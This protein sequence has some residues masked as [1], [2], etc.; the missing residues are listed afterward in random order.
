MKTKGNIFVCRIEGKT[1]KALKMTF[2]STFLL[3]VYVRQEAHYQ[4]RNFI[5]KMALW[6]AKTG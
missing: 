1:A 6:A 4:K 3:F 5:K 2:Y